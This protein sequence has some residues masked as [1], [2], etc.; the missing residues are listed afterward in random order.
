MTAVEVFGIRHHGPGSARS[1]VAALDRFGSDLILVEGPPEAS[2]LI[3]LVSD[4]ELRPPVAILAYDPATPMRSTFFPFA[5]FS[6]EWQALRFGVE[7]GVE[8][9]F[10]D[11]SIGRLL[12]AREAVRDAEAPRAADGG[13]L[14]ETDADT[15]D[16]E[17]EPEE[18]LRLD[19]IGRLGEAIGEDGERWWDRFIEHRRDPGE[20]FAAIAELMA[21]LREGVPSTPADLLRE[22]AMRQAI[23]DGERAG[24]ARI[25]FV[26]GA[27]HVPALVDRDDEATNAIADAAVLATLETTAIEAT[28]VPWSESHLSTWSGYGAGIASPGWYLHLW[29]GGRPL[30]EHWLVRVAR[31]L[32][33]E[34]FDISPAHLIEA[35]RLAETTA[36]IRGR[37]TPG[38]GEVNEAIRAVLTSGSD[39]PMALIAERLIIGTALGTVPG[40]VDTAPLARDLA[41]EQRRLRLKAEVIERT[42][43]L[44]LR[45]ETDRGRSHLL[46]RLRVL[47]VPWGV[48]AVDTRRAMGTFREPWRL[49][50]DPMFA[51]ALVAQSRWGNTISE[52]AS[53]RLVAEAADID[54]LDELSARL[55]LSMYADLPAA[56]AGLSGRVGALAA[57]SA[58]VAALLAA[59]PALARA[60]RYGSVREL[61]V[62][63]LGGVIRAILQRAAVGLPSAVT[64]LDDDGAAEMVRH[65]EEGAEAV[66]ILDDQDLRDV[67]AGALRAV[68]DRNGVHGRIVGRCARLLLDDRRME[69]DESAERLSGALS[70]GAAP[71]Y[72]MGYLDGFLAGSGALLVHDTRLFGLVD[73]WLVD[74]N[75]AGFEASLPYLRRTFARFSAPE[76]RALR[77]KARALATATAPT[78]GSAATAPE[79]SPPGPAAPSSP[80]PAPDLDLLDSILG[81]GGPDE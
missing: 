10:A 74:Q 35:S 23:R 59:L 37:G 48:P 2:R 41:A 36:A 24:A 42:F 54:R 7:R 81:L 14:A 34:G 20:V 53:A 61:D 47:D 79:P 80:E 27:Y 1:L 29:S 60:L 52:A 75:D 63:G 46:H 11:L 18:A 77:D 62:V 26:C 39:V 17:P 13:D 30:V 5:Q 12:L 21:E 70:R 28:W 33:E 32:R 19:P 55:E 65:V 16:G 44:D 22:A 8:T 50:W 25:A 57:V 38:L 56:T 4:P 31:L 9:R 43:E 51:V 58:D 45:T 3:P 49:R 66:A 76:R 72:T 15:P 73:G 78:G 68:C 67:W 64:G 6:P 40:S 69:A 71:E